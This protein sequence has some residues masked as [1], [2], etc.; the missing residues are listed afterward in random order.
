MIVVSAFYV[1]CWMPA[2]TYYLVFNLAS[3]IAFNE[4]GYYA[5]VFACFFYICANPFIYAVK[6]DP[7]KRVLLTLTPCKKTA[8]LAEGVDVTA[9]RS[10]TARAAQE[11]TSQV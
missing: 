1:V 7:V 5:A 4:S 8:V 11:R 3:N 9:T 10:G 2:F 6:F